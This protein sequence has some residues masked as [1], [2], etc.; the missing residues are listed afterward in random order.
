MATVNMDKP[1]VVRKVADRV[2][3]AGETLVDD[4]AQLKA[5]A[6]E[7]VD[8]GTLMARRAYARRVREFEDM[9]DEA[10]LKVRKA[11]F[12]AVGLTFAVGVLLG[13]VIG[14]VGRPPRS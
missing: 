11:P 2:A 14:W 4:A 5:R 8:E 9:K 7:L 1:E 3:A 6:G 13:V 10:A 12:T